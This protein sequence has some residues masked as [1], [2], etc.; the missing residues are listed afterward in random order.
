M[1]NLSKISL[2]AAVAMMAISATAEETWKSIGVGQYR[3]NIVHTWMSGING[4]PQMDVE[5]QESEATPGRYRIMDPYKNYPYNL[6]GGAPE[7]G[8]Y[9]I[10]DASDPVHCFIEMSPTKLLLGYDQ[11]KNKVQMALWSI[12]DD[13]YNNMEGNWEKADEEG[14]CGTLKNGCVTFPPHTVLTTIVYADKE[15]DWNMQWKRSNGEGMFRMRLPNAPHIDVDVTF[16]GFGGDD[17]AYAID[18]EKDVEYALVAMTKGEFDASTFTSIADGTL[19]S[20]KVT[21][22]TSVSMPYEEDGVFTLYVLPYYKGEALDGVYLQKEMNYS[23]SEWRKCG[24]V[25]Y[26]EAILSS[27]EMTE[28]GYTS[29]DPDTY[30]VEI[31]E[32][33]AQPGL[34]R[35]VNPYGPPY[36]YADATNYDASHNYYME[37]DATDPDAVVL[38]RMDPIGLSF[39]WGRMAIWSRADKFLQQ[40][41]TKE[42]LKQWEIFN[43]TKL[44]G[45][46]A[47][48]KIT[49]PKESLYWIIL[50]QPTT[51]TYWANSNGTFCIQHEEGQVKGGS[52]LSIIGSDNANAPE[53]WFT[54]DGRRLDRK[55]TANGI[56][57]CRKG[58]ESSKV[59]IR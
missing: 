14:V 7:D 55:P 48:N 26:T 10:V 54:I 56:Y 43:D 36:V 47:D 32:N 44:L 20:Q 22:S 41:M 37:I 33:V 51:P 49:F 42:E 53:Q 40:G 21:S 12:A 15:I 3:D 11:N 6:G 1:N 17:L 38:R 13:Y 29:I 24:E 30:W 25:L 4:F 59:V 46:H 39:S 35:L 50:D 27:N 52:A 2:S 58:C 18:M 34:F 28:S 57:V 5:I 31:E 16:E 45:K 19:K 9:I 23:E 8:G